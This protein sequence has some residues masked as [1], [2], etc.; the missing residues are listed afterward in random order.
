MDDVEYRRGRDDALSL[1]SVALTVAV[2]SDVLKVDIRHMG[3]LGMLSGSC[4]LLSLDDANADGTE[5][6]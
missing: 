2:V 6:P 3:P 4:L 1:S 5:P